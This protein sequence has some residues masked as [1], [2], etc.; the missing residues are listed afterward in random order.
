M[1]DALLFLKL[2][3][4]MFLTSLRHLL[5]LM[6][7]NKSNNFINGFIIEM[8]LP[9]N[10]HSLDLQKPVHTSLGALYQ[11]KMESCVT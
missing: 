1:T 4:V 5:H 2:I 9:T 3:I 11:Y 10:L 6:S 8:F 7:K